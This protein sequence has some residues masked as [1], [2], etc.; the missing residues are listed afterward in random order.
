MRQ[1]I[2]SNRSGASEVVG[3]SVGQSLIDW[4]KDTFGDA[5]VHEGYGQTEA[6]TLIG[7]CTALMEFREGTMGKPAVG[8]EVAIVDIDSAKLIQEPGTLGEI[9][10]RYED[11]PVCFKQYLNKP[12]KTTAKRHNGWHLTEDLGRIDAD[13][14]IAFE[15]RKDDVIISA[16]YRIGPEEI[17]ES[18]ASHNAAVEAGVIGVPDEERG[19]VP[20]AFV[21]L[22]GD[23]T[24]NETLSEELRHHVR[25][26]LAKYE[27]P[28][29]IEFVEALPKTATGKLQREQLRELER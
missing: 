15:G 6:N 9:A 20:K 25:D 10:V 3:K 23:V 26:R 28:R 8:H 22:A 18:L 4:A 27:Y 7:D 1:G 5:P 11:N 17:E 13:G 14:Y 12:E 19:E 16:G 29:E 2:L 21:V 24:G